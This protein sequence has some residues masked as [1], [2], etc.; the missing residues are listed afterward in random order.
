VV[1]IRT[2]ANNRQLAEGERQIE[3][4]E[5]AIS[6]LPAPVHGRVVGAPPGVRISTVRGIPSRKAQYAT[7][8]KEG[9][10]E[11]ISELQRVRYEVFS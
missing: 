11:L 3:D 10:D 7:L 5:G 4:L 8:S 2:R 9:V 6:V 1:R